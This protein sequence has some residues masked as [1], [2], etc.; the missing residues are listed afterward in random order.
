MIYFRNC[1]KAEYSK[2]VDDDELTAWL[3]NHSEK[4]TELSEKSD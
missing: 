2:L 1:K 4:I 3:W